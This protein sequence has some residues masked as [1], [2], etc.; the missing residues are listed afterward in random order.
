M[1][2]LRHYEHIVA[3]AE[4][5]NFRR[6]AEA[7]HISTPALTK[8]IQKSEKSFN[9][10]LFDRTRKGVMPTPF[11]ETVVRQARMLLRDAAAISRDVR[12]LAQL[13]CGHILVGCG[14]FAAEALMGNVM[15]RFL[16]NFPKIRVMLKVV[17]FPDMLLKMLEEKEIDFFI[18]NYPQHIRGMKILE[19]IKLPKE[20]I[21]WYCRPKH[22]LLKMKKFSASDIASFPLFLPFLTHGF[23]D[24]LLQVFE[25]TAVVQKNGVI[26]AAFQC[27]DYRIL[28]DAVA[29]SDGVGALPQTN[30][31]KELQ[32]R[33][34]YELLFRPSIPPP[35]WGIVYLRERIL[36]PAAEC[37]ISII[38]DECFRIV[39]TKQT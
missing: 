5:G 29:N 36:P 17:G 24:W 33:R 25:G 26:D 23:N 35:G 1:C 31:T 4:K 28:R 7:V 19:V 37:L 39:R 11:G 20:D 3:L 32:S 15:V 8:S 10:R 14:P 21:V 22:P 12:S 2:D 18:A 13:E 9:V 38:K 6:A 16:P 30:L 34:L 27:N